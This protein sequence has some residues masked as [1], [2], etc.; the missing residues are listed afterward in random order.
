[1]RPGGMFGYCLNPESVPS[2]TFAPS[3]TEPDAP[4]IG[5]VGVVCG[6]GC[7]IIAV[8]LA[9]SPLLMGGGTAWKPC[10]VTLEFHKWAGSTASI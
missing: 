8:L 9:V 4:W 3:G 10:L 2:I 5:L 1:M 6:G 7:Y